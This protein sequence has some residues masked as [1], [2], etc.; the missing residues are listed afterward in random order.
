MAI[1]KSA[2]KPDDMKT[3]ILESAKALVAARGFS[4]VGL[5]EIVAA[6][7]VRKGSFYYYFESKEACGRA[8]LEQNF[9]GYLTELDA[10]LAD[11]RIPARDRLVSY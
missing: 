5:S 2:E 1:A 7:G 6:S 10:M 11:T 3:H 9:D 8:L 4:G